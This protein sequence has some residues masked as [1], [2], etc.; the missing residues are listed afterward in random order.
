MSPN[1]NQSVDQAHH[2]SATPGRRKEYICH[3][4]KF[5]PEGRSVSKSTFFRHA[6]HRQAGGIPDS[7]PINGPIVN[8]VP[9][10]PSTSRS[11]PTVPQIPT[12]QEFNVPFV[13]PPPVISPPVENHHPIPTFPTQSPPSTNSEP[14][15]LS[16]ELISRIIRE[17]THE[18][19]LASGNIAYISLMAKQQAYQE[20][21]DVF[22]RALGNA[23]TSRNH[24]NGS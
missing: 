8:P 24:P 2:T 21:M 18:Q 19:L 23:A 4:P 17:A 15:A 14:A 12:Q 3:C 20:C 13:H 10:D 7:Q 16:P 5:C 6:E 22:T 11:P 1:P 9:S